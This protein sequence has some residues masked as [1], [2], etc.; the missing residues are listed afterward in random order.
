MPYRIKPGQEVMLIMRDREEKHVTFNRQ[1]DFT[2]KELVASPLTEHNKDGIPKS[3][4]Q[5]RNG[6]LADYE[7]GF[8]VSEKWSDGDAAND[9]EYLYAIEVHQVGFKTD[10]RANSV[11]VPGSRANQYTIIINSDNV[12]KSCTCPGHR[13]QR[14]TCKHMRMVAERIADGGEL[15]FMNQ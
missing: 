13:F 2:K 10:A 1:V 3:K 4:F 11:I 12:V 14:K 9:V 6:M 15:D 8:D 5:S 7:W